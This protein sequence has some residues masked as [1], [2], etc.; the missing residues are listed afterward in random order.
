MD[1]W[2][3]VRVL[4]IISAGV[5]AHI[6]IIQREKI[7]IMRRDLKIAL[8]AYNILWKMY[9]EK[10][11]QERESSVEQSKQ[12]QNIFKKEFADK[13]KKTREFLD[14]IPDSREEKH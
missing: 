2:R 3:V 4:M 6:A 14:S 1:W 9:H 8:K 13:R 10:I 11:E 7:A 12:R 5:L